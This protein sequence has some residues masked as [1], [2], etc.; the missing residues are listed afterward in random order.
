[1]IK[2]ILITRLIFELNVP[3]MIKKQISQ[4]VFYGVKLEEKV[5]LH[6]RYKTC[7]KRFIGVKK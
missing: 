7:K 1:M 3:P 2:T 6:E 4:C 5:N